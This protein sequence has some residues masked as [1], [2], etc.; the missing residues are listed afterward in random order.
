MSRKFSSVG[1]IDTRGA[2]LGAILL[3]ASVA[4][5]ATVINFEGLSDSD[6]IGRIGAAEFTDTYVASAGSS[7]NDLEFPPNSGINVVYN[8]DDMINVR[9]DDLMEKVGAFVTYTSPVFLQAFDDNGVL[10]TTVVSLYFANTA[11]TGDPGAAPNEY[12]EVS[13]LSGIRSVLFSTGLLGP[14]FVIDDL[15]FEALAGPGPGPGPGL[16]E[17][18]TALLIL[19]GLVVARD[20]F[21]K[22]GGPK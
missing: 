8:P 9:F 12:L 16:P 18:P 17:P 15:T 1:L 14:T 13:A 22:R 20:R 2:V 19:L 4:A 21:M 7:L 10:V 3:F 6:M 11:L 5:P